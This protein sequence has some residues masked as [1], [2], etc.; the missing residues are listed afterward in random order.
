MQ[1]VAK[2]DGKTRETREDRIR[3]PKR[4]LTKPPGRFSNQYTLP[5]DPA[6]NKVYRGMEKV[7][8]HRGLRVAGV[9]SMKWRAADVANSP[10]GWKDDGTS[11]AGHEVM[12]Q[13]CIL[14]S[15]LSQTSAFERWPLG[16]GCRF[17]E[18]F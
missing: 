4:I 14:P 2:Q 10:G 11:G 8:R 13:S 15:G 7:P 17:L 12:R 1:T 5:P 6:Q 3:I 18:I 9:G 16:A